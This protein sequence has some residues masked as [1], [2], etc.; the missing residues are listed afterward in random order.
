M[1]KQE[2]MDIFLDA[3]AEK[4]GD[5][6]D[7]RGCYVNTDYGNEWFSVRRIKDLIIKTINENDFN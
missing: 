4:Y 7:D 6:D 1:D 3:L 5:I 2:V